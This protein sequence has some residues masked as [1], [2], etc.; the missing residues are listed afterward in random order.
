MNVQMTDIRIWNDSIE[1]DEIVFKT[2]NDVNE[3]DGFYIL[4]NS[5]YIVTNEN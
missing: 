1:I 2:R 3:T 5:E 4:S